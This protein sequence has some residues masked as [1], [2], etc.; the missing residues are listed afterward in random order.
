LRYAI[1]VAISYVHVLPHASCHSRWRRIHRAGIAPDLLS[2]GGAA[3]WG[4]V[5]SPSLETH[6]GS[7]QGRAGTT[8]HGGNPTHF[9]GSYA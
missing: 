5:D 4:R 7:H 9:A 6:H 3:G 8:P 2:R 1:G